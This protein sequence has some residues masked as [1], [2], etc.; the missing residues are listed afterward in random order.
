MDTEPLVS[1][2]VPIYNVE[3]YLREC[4]D[5][6]CNQTYR[7]IEI[8]LV[9]DGSTDGSEVIC[10]EYLTRDER[11]ILINKDNGGLSSARNAGISVAKGEYIGFIDSDDIV[12]HMFVETMIHALVESGCRVV[13]CDYCTEIKNMICM[14]SDYSVLSSAEAISGLLDDYGYRCSAWDKMYRRECFNDL[15]FPEGKIYEDI[16]LMYQLFK[17]TESIAYIKHPL[18]FYRKRK[19]S[20]TKSCFSSGVY[21]LLESLDYVR[22]DSSS[23]KEV[24]HNRVLVGYMSYYMG[25]FIRKGLASNEDINTEADHLRNLVKKNN[26]VLIT[27]RS[28]RFVKK[29]ELIL[30]AFFPHIYNLLLRLLTSRGM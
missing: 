25:L 8:I 19:G 24:D 9:N 30:F 1:I 18:Y 4:L 27:S 29:T 28:I 16:K 15:L 20:I 26:K 7:N 10:E 21:F 5:S 23:I 2:I 13:V 17:R 11:I 3:A 14:D 22:E 12:H 6:V